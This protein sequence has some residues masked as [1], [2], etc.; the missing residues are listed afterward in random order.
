MAKQV[1]I[2]L[3]V[4]RFP[5]TDD[6]KISVQHL[7]HYLGDYE[8]TLIAPRSLEISDPL[9]RSLPVTRFADEYFTGI[10]GYNKLMLS[11]GFYD[12]F[13]AYEYILIYQ[14]DCLVFSKDLKS[15]CD[16][17]WDYVGAPWFR[18]YKDDTSE[19]FWAVGNGG[20][21]LRRVS[22][23][24]KVLRSRRL[25][26][27]PIELGW[28]T[29]PFP[30]LPGFRFLVRVLKTI[31]H[32]CGYRNT[33][34]YFVAQYDQYEDIFWSFHA[35]RAVPDFKIPTPQEALPF[36]FEFA[37]R[38]CFEKNGRRLPFACHAW[39]K[40]DAAFWQEVLATQ[41]TLPESV[42]ATCGKSSAP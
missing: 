16:K 17:G 32:A 31:L 4:Y 41:P 12:A 21:S 34:R 5:L 7:L 6:E 23:F 15:W 13:K 25:L 26:A 42:A 33:M 38:Y 39:H 19:G 40:M 27:S 10:P 11:R 8:L 24:R 36:A 2:T 29:R 35:K 20:L 1:I 18:G 22:T 37:P 14:L 28:N 3:P 30:W 9:L